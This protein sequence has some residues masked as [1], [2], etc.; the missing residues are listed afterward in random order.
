MA[1]FAQLDENNIVINVIKVNNEDMID[2]NGNESEELGLQ[3]CQSHFPGTRWVQ[4]SYNGNMR[5]L[6]AGKGM[7]YLEEYDIF[8]HPAPYPSWIFDPDEKTWNPPS[9]YPVDLRDNE[10]TIIIWDESNLEWNVTV[11]PNPFIDEDGNP[12]YNTTYLEHSWKPGL[13]QWVLEEVEQ[14]DVEQ[15]DNP[16]G[17]AST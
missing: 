17:I 5:D 9:P 16:V 10:G 7:Q 11:V 2:E 12:T 3:V 8:I 4:T 13:C 6:F 1:H 15:P 14:P